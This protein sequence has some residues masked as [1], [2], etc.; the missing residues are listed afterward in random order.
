MIYGA[1]SSITP[2]NPKLANKSWATSARETTI[3]VGYDGIT[4]YAIVWAKLIAKLPILS[5]G[6]GVTGS[7]E[8]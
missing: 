5:F 3:T 6:R 1:D 8:P 2:K 7:I 4:D